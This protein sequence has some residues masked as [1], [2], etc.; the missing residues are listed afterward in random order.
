ML[1]KKKNV[2]FAATRVGNL[3]ASN[4][5]QK[6]RKTLRKHYLLWICLMVSTRLK[7]FLTHKS[8]CL[9]SFSSLCQGLYPSPHLG[10]DT[11]QKWGCLAVGAGA[12]GPGGFGKLFVSRG[13]S[14][15]F[16]FLRTESHRPHC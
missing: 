13:Q 5:A 8:Q 11:W 9:H 6:P 16:A 7:M 2:G 3:L 10:G 14:L 4:P 12:A 15:V 1:S